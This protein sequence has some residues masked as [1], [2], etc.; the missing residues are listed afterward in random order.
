MN[1]HQVGNSNIHVCRA[2]MDQGTQG[3]SNIAC[4]VFQLRNYFYLI[5]TETRM[6][7]VEGEGDGEVTVP[8]CIETNNS[9]VKVKRNHK[10]K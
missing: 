9:T 8:V 7:L 3:I 5:P 2:T 1:L 10:G 4:F 6:S